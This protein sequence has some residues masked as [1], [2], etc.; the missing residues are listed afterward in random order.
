MECV[1]WVS[2][3]QLSRWGVIFLLF[4][5]QWT[6]SI[7]NYLELFLEAASIKDLTTQD[8]IICKTKVSNVIFLMTISCSKLTNN[9]KKCIS[10]YLQ[11]SWRFSW[12]FLSWAQLVI[13]KTSL[14][15]FTRLKFNVSQK[16]PKERSTYEDGKAMFRLIIKLTFTFTFTI[17]MTKVN[18]FATGTR[19]W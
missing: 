9:M 3:R 5:G 16:R 15:S 14:T 7:N 8:T 13:L 19:A 10:F 18:H 12:A 6:R 1:W 17:Y 2:T 4:Q 11:E